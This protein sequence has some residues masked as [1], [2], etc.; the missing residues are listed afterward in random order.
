MKILN[1]YRSV[2]TFWFF[3]EK[4]TN[5]SVA[6]FC[7]SLMKMNWPW[8]PFSIA[9][10]ITFNFLYF[11]ARTPQEYLE[12]FYILITTF[13]D[14]ALLLML[15]WK[16]E[17]RFEIIEEL[18]IE[19]EKR[20]FNSNFHIIKQNVFQFKFQDQKIQYPDKFT[21]KPMRS[22]RNGHECCISSIWALFLS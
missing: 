17:Y 12:C 20:K 18:E 2:V 21:K 15:V 11:E 16:K 5:K 1:S 19:I 13:T 9:I 14:S 7:L 6:N 3:H 8:I 4:S 10:L 22:S